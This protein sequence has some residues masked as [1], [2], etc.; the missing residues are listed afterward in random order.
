MLKMAG[1]N[2]WVANAFMSQDCY[3]VQRETSLYKMI[4]DD[5]PVLTFLRHIQQDKVY[6]FSS[7]TTS[8]RPHTT[9]LK[10]CHLPTGPQEKKK[11]PVS[12]K[13]TDVNESGY[14]TRATTR[15]L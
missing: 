3:A 8:P 7:R 1:S 11:P 15:V 12:G 10:T 14:D 13:D 6:I 2:A 4:S 9:L 5:G